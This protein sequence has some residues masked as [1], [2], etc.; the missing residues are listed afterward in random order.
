[1]KKST[2]RAPLTHRVLFCARRCHA[3]YERHQKGTK[4]SE[5]EKGEKPCVARK[6]NAPRSVSLG[7]QWFEV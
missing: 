1:M 4:H 3:P 6:K 7:A 5:D 2:V